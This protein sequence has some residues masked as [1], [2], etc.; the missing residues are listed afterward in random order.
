MKLLISCLIF[1]PGPTT[2]KDSESDTSKLP[3]T[4]SSPII[5]TL[6]LMLLN[7]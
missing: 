2:F 3:F 4:T 7:S 5:Y 6:K 1:D